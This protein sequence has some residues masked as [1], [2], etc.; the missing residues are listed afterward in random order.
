MGFYIANKV[1]SLV[2]VLGVAGF[3]NAQMAATPAEQNLINKEKLATEL[4]PK[5]LSD[6]Q[7]ILGKTASRLSRT[8]WSAYSSA[9]DGLRGRAKEEIG[10]YKVEFK[11]PLLLNFSSDK[12]NSSLETYY[13]FQVEP[14]YSDGTQLRRDIWNIGAE[15]GAPLTVAGSIRVTFTRRFKDSAAAMTALPYCYGVELDVFDLC[16]DHERK[17][18]TTVDDIKTRLN[19]GDSV[20]VEIFGEAGLSTDHANP[21]HVL[22]TD[23]SAKYAKSALFIVDI[24]KHTA[25]YVRARFIGLKNRGTMS[26]SAEALLMPGWMPSNHFL[27]R[28][29]KVGAWVRWSNTSDFQNEYPLDSLMVDYLY[30]FSS[31]RPVPGNGD[32]KGAPVERATSEMALE[33]VLNQSY[34]LGFLSLF[35]PLKSTQEVGEELLKK[36]TLSAAISKYDHKNLSD[37]KIRGPEVRVRT[38]FKGRISADVRQ[39]EFAGKVS[40]LAGASTKPSNIKSFIVN[41]DLDDAKS[42]YIMEGATDLTSVEFANARW[43]ILSSQETDL[44]MTATENKQPL[45]INDIVVNNRIQDKNQS[46][47]E[48]SAIR[49]RIIM[50]L[51]KIYSSDPKIS[52]FFPVN[53]D[54][55]KATLDFR[56]NYGDLAFHDIYNVNQAE[57]YTRLYNFLNKHPMRTELNLPNDSSEIEKQNFTQYVNDMYANIVEMIAPG[58]TPTRRLSIY[59]TLLNDKA[60]RMV[61]LGEFFS[62]L[63]SDQGAKDGMGLLLGYSSSQTPTKV[64]SIGGLKSSDIY[65]AVTYFR[66]V[67]T[68]RSNDLRLETIQTEDGNLAFK[69]LEQSLEQ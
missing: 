5:N 37:G 51:P 8:V 39:L 36:S 26:A 17:L 30:H 52:G 62:S 63:L 14:S 22:R 23:V 27:Q 9:L 32:W 33:E 3:A 29:L 10:R 35:D 50:S 1:V 41:Y 38:L 53:Q 34:A 54:Q 19:V 48:L 7:T 64:E 24:Y 46:V 67:V 15:V 16:Q 20:R 44:L 60:F 61:V 13:E 12:A 66:S 11:I 31:D 65:R 2:L 28:I 40:F 56:Y 47:K 42:Y 45:V 69:P 49:E 59:H 4:S 6:R 18:P 21:S 58:T 25:D 55:S 43:K 68:N 57:L